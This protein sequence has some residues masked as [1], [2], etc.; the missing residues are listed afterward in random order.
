VVNA[1]PTNSPT[2]RDECENS[3][4]FR[5]R[6]KS[7]K[8][9]DSYVAIDPAT[10]CRKFVDS[11]LFLVSPEEDPDAKRIKFHCPATCRKRCK[12]A[13]R[14]SA[15]SSASSSAPSSASP[16]AS[17]S[18]SPST[19]PSLSPFPTTVRFI[20]HGKLRTSSQSIR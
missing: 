8:T 9:C 3:F 1:A 10:R 2:D 17:P 11:N 14:P 18:S 4:L 7:S 13:D 20:F 6:G 12:N 16:S 19:S 5:Y 15:S